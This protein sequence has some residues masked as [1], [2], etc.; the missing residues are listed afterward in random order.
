[1]INNKGS[2]TERLQKIIGVSTLSNMILEHPLTASAVGG[3]WNISY[4]TLNSGGISHL[5][6]PNLGKSILLNSTVTF[7]GQGYLKETTFGI[8]AGQFDQHTNLNNK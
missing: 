6:D 1:M 2:L 8:A 4:N 3:V 7:G 5:S